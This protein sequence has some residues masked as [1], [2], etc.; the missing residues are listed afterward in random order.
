MSQNAKKKKKKKKKGFWSNGL[1]LNSICVLKDDAVDSRPIPGAHFQGSPEMHSFPVPICRSVFSL[2][3][4]I[5][6]RG[7]NNL[8]FYKSRVF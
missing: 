1:K 5:R 2:I 6:R 8:L 4:S 3:V 7:K